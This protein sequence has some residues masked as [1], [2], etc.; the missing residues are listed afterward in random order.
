MSKQRVFHSLHFIMT[1]GILVL[2]VSF[3]VFPNIAVAQE[4][5]PVIEDEIYEEADYAYGTVSSISPTSLVLSEYDIDSDQFLEVSYQIAPD[6]ELFNIESIADIKNGDEVDV[7]FITE[8]DQ[9]V[10]VGLSLY[11]E[12]GTEEEV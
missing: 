5:A 4:E 9:K 11:E 8:N 10:V 3:P 2:A 6:V 12:T 7:D 1:A